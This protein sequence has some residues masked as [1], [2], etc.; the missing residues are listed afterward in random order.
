[1]WVDPL[2]CA[3]RDSRGKGVVCSRGTMKLRMRAKN[4][5]LCINTSL[6]A[7]VT[8]KLLPC[9]P[10]KGR[11]HTVTM[12]S[13]HINWLSRHTV[14]RRTELTGDRAFVAK[15]KIKVGHMK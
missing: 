14:A 2:Q 5:G 13:F 3:R 4:V 15:Q 12:S 6:A 11:K 1:M 10:E 8:T 7:Q 9:T